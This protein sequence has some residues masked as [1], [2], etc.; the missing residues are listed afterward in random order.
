[1]TD[2]ANGRL[3]D[4]RPMTPHI[5]AEIFGVDLRSPLPDEAIAE[6]RAALLKWKVVF[7][8]DQAIGPAEQISFGRRFGEVTPAHVILPSIE[9][10]PE[11]LP[12]GSKEY[13]NSNPDAQL[14]DAW[15]TD[16]TFTA[17]PPMGSILRGVVVP[18]YG[19]DTQWTNLVAAYEGLSEPLRAFVDSLRAV[20]RNAIPVVQGNDG[21]SERLKQFAGTS[22]RTIHPVVRV[23][24]ETGERALFVNPFFTEGILGLRRDE[25]RRILE[26]LFDQITKPDYIVR[27]RWAPGSIAFWDNRAT[28]HRAPTDVAASGFER[29]M[30]RITIAGEAPV[31][32]DG[33]VSR[34]A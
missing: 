3:V 1:M 32:P 17:T 18:P 2:V 28:A 27:F 19:G 30:E 22:T 4:V 31:G 13:K 29:Y 20:H 10:F 24:P 8:R 6:I 12:L 33:F 15:H 23:H 14:D 9:G 25:S 5:G 16:V 26:L 7:F 21:F 34:P 11:V